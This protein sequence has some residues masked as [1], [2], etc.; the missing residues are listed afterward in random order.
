MKNVNKDSQALSLNRDFNN[1]FL[2]KN[3][4]ILN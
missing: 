2:L 4:S 1:K 3:I